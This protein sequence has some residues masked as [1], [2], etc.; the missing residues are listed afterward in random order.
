MF[1]GTDERWPMRMHRQKVILHRSSMQAYASSLEKQGNFVNYLA[2]PSGAGRTESILESALPAQTVGLHVADPVDEILSRR[3]RRICE[4]KGWRLNV[5]DTPAF[6]SPP[7]FLDECF[8]GRQKPFMARFYQRQRVRMGL[9]VS[10]EGTPLGGRWSYDEENR[11]RLPAHEPVAPA[12]WLPRNRLTPELLEEVGRLFPKAS[13]VPA[14]FVYPSTHDE[15]SEWLDEFLER[16][17][18][19]FGDYE[20]AIS[21]KYA[22][23]FHSLLTPALNIGLLTPG[24]IVERTLLVAQAKR[25]PLNSL[26][27]FIRQIVGWREFIRAMY[28]RRGN[29]MRR[30]NFWGFSRRMP[31]AFYNGTTGIEPVDTVVERLLKTGYCHHIERLMLLGNFML[32]CRIHPDEVYRWFMEMFVDSYDWVMVPNVYGM[33]Q[34]ADGGAF[35]TKPYL[36]GSNYLLKMSDFPRGPWC[37]IWDALFWTFIADYKDVFLANPRMNM[38]ARLVEKQE[39]K[40]GEQRRIAERFISR[41]E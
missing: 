33:S 20:D 5:Y 28:E 12:P 11:R 18:L 37:A 29:A 9:L 8:G 35:T 30:Q 1:M 16:R 26:E 31:K 22:V 38:M 14:P 6:L 17:L 7:S 15:A 10:P 19:R 3:L 39:A 24:Q 13:G 4:R 34:F 41:L 40:L 23:I 21:A 25:T 2:C 32:L 36:S 27:G